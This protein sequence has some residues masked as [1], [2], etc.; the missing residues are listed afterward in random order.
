MKKT[1]GKKGFGQW[2]VVVI[3]MLLASMYISSFCV[4]A[5]SG[6]VPVYLTQAPSDIDVSVDDEP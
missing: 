2:T 3:I 4:Y 6:T 5:A 1:T